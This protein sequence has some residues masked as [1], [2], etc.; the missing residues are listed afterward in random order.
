MTMG[1]VPSPPIVILRRASSVVVLRRATSVVILRRATSC[2]YSAAHLLCCHSEER[3]TKNLRC[4]D[5]GRVVV[6]MN[7]PSKGDLRFLTPFGM[8]MRGSE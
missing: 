1:G 6:V 4:L 3:T 7:Q 8:T 5:S 2:W